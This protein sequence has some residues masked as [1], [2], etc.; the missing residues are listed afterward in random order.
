MRKRSPTS[1]D[2]GQRSAS[3]QQSRTQ[4]SQPSVAGSALLVVMELGAEWPGLMQADASAR[5]V[6][7]QVDGETPVAFAERISASLDSLFG[8]GVRLE[9]VALACN[10][11]IDEAA[12][13]ARRKLGS[14]TLGTMALHKAGRLSFTAPPRSSGRLRHSLSA[15]SRALFDEWRTAGLDVTVEFGE[16]TR[17]SEVASPAPR[18]ARVA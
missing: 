13:S 5:R 10:E 3:S 9:T 7:V 6:L 16:E 18:T 2:R 14:L 17:S 8:K 12:D 11:R 4:A 15:L 1:S